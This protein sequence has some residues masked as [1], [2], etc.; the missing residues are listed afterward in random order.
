[1]VRKI[2]HANGKRIW[3]VRG[4][5]WALR[6]VRHVTGLADKAFGS[7]CYDSAL[8]RYSQEYCLKNLSQ[9]IL[10]TET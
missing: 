8:S 9:A 2:A 1:M 6:L 10:E 3:M 4:F 5:T 7:L